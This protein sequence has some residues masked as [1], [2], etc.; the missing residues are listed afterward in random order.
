MTKRILI[1]GVSSGIGLATAQLLLEKGYSVTG[2]SRKPEVTA[3]HQDK[4]SHVQLDLEQ[5]N[6]IELC[7]NQLLKT[8]SFDG[9]VHAAGYGEFGSIEQFSVAQIERAMQVNL[10]SALLIA[11]QLVPAFR[12]QQ[13]GQLIFIGSESALNAGR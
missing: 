5:S 9:F 10:T 13:S 6:D 12:K 3:I 1:T 4:F 11:R 7:L 2:I 8:T